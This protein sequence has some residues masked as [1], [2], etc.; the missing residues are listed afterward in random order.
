MRRARP[1]G[2][3]GR[4]GRGRTTPDHALLLAGSP[5]VEN[6]LLLALANLLSL[7]HLLYMLLGVT[8]GLVVGILP[9]LGGIA[10][11]SLLLPFIYGMDV[12]SALAMLMGLVAVIPTSDTFSS[13]LMGIPGSA[14]AQAT[15][16][17]G[18]PLAKRGEAARA[19]SAAFAAS[20]I[21]GLFGAV[22]LSVFVLVARPLILAFG[23]AELFMLTIFGLSMVGV[24]SGAHLGKGLASCAV[25]LALGLVG[26]APATGEYRMEFG[27]LY[28]MDGLPLVIVGLGLFAVPEIVDLLRGGGAI[29]G[30]AKLGQGWIQ[31][32]RDTARNLGLTLRCSGL[33]AI[34]GAIPGIGGSVIDW[35][36]YGHVVQTAKDK[37]QFGKGDIRGVIA[38]ESA[39]NAKD[40]GALVPT[41]LFG[42]PGSGSM[43]IF[44]AGMILLG[45]QP[46][47]AMVGR[48]LHLTYTIVW[49]LAIANVMGTILCILL[50]PAIARLTT[51][52]FQLIAP[53]MILVISFAAFQATRS[54]WDLVALLALGILGLLMRRFGWSR[55]AFLIGFVLAT[56]SERYLY[57]A[58][59][60]DGWGFFLKPIVL[61][62]FALILLSTWFGAR[63]RRSE[64]GTLHTEGPASA[65]EAGALWPQV[66]FAA[67]MLAL[68]AWMLAEVWS[69]SFLGRVFPLG[70]AAAGIL[71]TGLVLAELRRG[72][73]SPANFDGEAGPRAPH[74]RGPWYYVAW[75]A[76]LVGLTALVGFFAALVLFFLAFLR[77]VARTSWPATLALTAAGTA[78]LLA[79]ANALLLIFPGGLLQASVDLPWPLR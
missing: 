54:L 59:Q 34:L 71:A 58:V 57:Q 18:F 32:V 10:G 73:T 29:S 50:S 39:N 41:L 51:I 69:L 77:V 45:I 47:P 49:S 20:F 7:N 8:V 35:I 27:T 21:G 43:A 64:G 3:A 40:G 26:A 68:F 2:S 4:R 75:I 16:L 13:V 56:Q 70:V 5:V 23:S 22:L 46:G 65:A 37:S 72:E 14:S 63:S 62:I 66:L 61:V 78:F 31:G 60:F 30:E 28:L 15:V 67:A 12:T 48:N 19:L 9:A 25:G 11:M 6:A 42:I 74:D 38:P 52:R 24:L 1:Q 17:D 55:P 76:G 53:F 79:L 44:L 36:A 33:G